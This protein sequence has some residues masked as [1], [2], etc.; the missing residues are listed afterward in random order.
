MRCVLGL[1][2]CEDN[3]FV[4]LGSEMI[5]INGKQWNTQCLGYWIDVDFGEE[6]TGCVMRV[7]EKAGVDMS[8]F[9]WFGHFTEHL[10]REDLERV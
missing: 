4:A 1:K 3:E 7:I 8:N 10:V 6:V 2:F 9:S 5:A